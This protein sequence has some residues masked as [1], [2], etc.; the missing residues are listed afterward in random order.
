MNNTTFTPLLEKLAKKKSTFQKLKDNKVPLTSEERAEVMKS[1][2]VWHHGL[3]GSPSPAVWKSDDKNGNVTY[4]TNT[5][6]A[7]NTAPT[8]KGA[9]GRYHKFIKSTA[10]ER[11]GSE[12]EKLAKVDWSE[13][14]ANLK[15]RKTDDIENTVVFDFDGV[16]NSYKSGWKGPT[17]IP[18]DPVEGI[19]EEIKRIRDAGYRVIVV[20]ARC[21]QEGGIEAIKAYLKKHDIKVDGVADDKPPALCYID[22][23]G[24]PFDG[25]S[26]GLL[27][28]IKN[29]VPWHRR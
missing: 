13:R 17:N 23:N 2:A 25:E 15:K 16:I 7:Y 28:K 11:Y 20:S 26:K 14:L 8:L 9:I 18:D 4:I 3:G 12:I 29:H 21:F 19:K 6:R 24:I 10:S 5:H 1:K 27:E 22:D